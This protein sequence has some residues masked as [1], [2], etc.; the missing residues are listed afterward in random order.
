M[1]S[2]WLTIAEFAS[3]AGIVPRVGRKIAKA[4][5]WRG[6]Q[7][8]VRTVRGRGGR[9]GATYEVLAASLPAAFQEGLKALQIADERPSTSAAARM[10]WAWWHGVLSPALDHARGSQARGEALRQIAAKRHMRPDGMLKRISLRTLH[11]KLDAYENRQGAISL[12]R[13]QRS[14]RGAKR[15][16]VTTNF[17]RAFQGDAA[18]KQRIADALR[19]YIRAQQK[20]LESLSNIVFKA[21]FKL[22]EL[23]RAE[24][25]ELPPDALHIP[26]HLVRS[27]KQHQAIGIFKKDRKKFE[28]NQPGVQRSFERYGPAGVVFGDIHHLDIIVDK[29]D[30]YQQFPKAIAWLDAATN[31]LHIDVVLLREG[32]GVRNE[33]VIASFLRMCH[34]WGLPRVLYID[35]G[36][37][38]NWSDFAADALQLASG[39]GSRLIVHAKPYNARAKPIEGIFGVLEQHYFAKLPGYVGGD[40][41]KTKTSNVGRAPAPFGPIHEYEAALQ[42]ILKFYHAKPQRG[43]TLAG[44][45]PHQAFKDYVDAGWLKTEVDPD[46]FAVAFSTPEPRIVRQGVIRHDAH[47]WYCDDLIGFEGQRVTALVPKFERWHCLPV[48]LGD[49]RIVFAHRDRVYDALD[50]AGAR[51]ASRRRSLGVQYIRALDKSAPAIDPVAETLEFAGFL[52]SP[53]VQPVGQRIT[54]SDEARAI[55]SRV[56]ESARDRTTREQEE[57]AANERFIQDELERARRRR[58]LADQRATGTR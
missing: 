36:S 46:A 56:R 30:G 21:Q 26:D 47:R 44:R 32:E 55:G 53:P 14:D 39:D 20:N 12:A 49:G 43:R 28:D 48:R 16:I 50:P 34:A 6:A 38:Y 5:K 10:D 4:G 57:Q 8:V 25:Y 13:R 9:A 24:G 3:L 7:L 15:A 58:R 51:E 27:E 29:I 31:R 2:E 17:D 41:M 33:H 35:N 22:A 23:A 19:D 11:R 54:A 52:P 42:A 37:E 1:A 18:A 40:R 45:S